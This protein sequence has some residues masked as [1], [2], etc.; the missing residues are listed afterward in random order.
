MKKGGLSKLD[1]ALSFGII[2]AIVFFLTSMMALMGFL[3]GSLTLITIFK[4]IYGRMGYD[5]TPFRALLGA[6]YAFIDAFILAWIFAW[7]YNKFNK[8]K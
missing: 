4:E 8:K 2:V 1:F 7:L 5:L 3:G 6:L